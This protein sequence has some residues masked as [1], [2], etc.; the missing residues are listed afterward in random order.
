MRVS[1]SSRCF[2]NSSG[3]EEP[4]LVAMKR[5]LRTSASAMPI[6]SSLSV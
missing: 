1:E 2:Q 3:V 6:F 4:V 5:F